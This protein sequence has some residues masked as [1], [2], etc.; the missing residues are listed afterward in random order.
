MSGLERYDI[1]TNRDRHREEMQAHPGGAYVT[2]VDFEAAIS[3]EREDL[4]WE[5]VERAAAGSEA[6]RRGEDQDA[7]DAIEAS[8]AR[9]QMALHDLRGTLRKLVADLPAAF[10]ALPPEVQAEYRDCEDSVIRA[11]GGTVPAPSTEAGSGEE[12]R[13]GTRTDLK[14]LND[15]WVEAARIARAFHDAYEIAAPRHNYK[16]RPES[17]KPWHAIPPENRDLMVD[18]VHDLLLAGVISPQPLPDERLEKA[19]A[20]C[21]AT[22]SS[23]IARLC[24]ERLDP[25]G[26]LLGRV[27]D[28]ARAAL[29]AA[30]HREGEQ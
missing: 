29:S 1:V 11:R 16:T 19:L 24:D 14:R 9:D 18:T 25:T 13:E 26:A 30:S 12:R 17:A 21:Y 28:I 8:A 5:N 4:A 10:D 20:A 7:L 23:A 6:K 27:R 22:D 3:L 2:Y 15:C